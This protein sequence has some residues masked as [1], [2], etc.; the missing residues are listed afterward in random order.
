MRRND[1]G[2]SDGWHFAGRWGRA[3]W[4]LQVWC[5]RTSIQGDRWV[6]QPSF[7]W[8]RKTSTERAAQIASPRQYGRTDAVPE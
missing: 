2:F 8:D 7:V 6:F 3:R 4:G 1:S 5:H